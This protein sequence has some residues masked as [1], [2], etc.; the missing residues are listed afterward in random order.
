MRKIFVNS[1]IF[2]SVFL[3]VFMVIASLNDKLFEFETIFGCVYS[4]SIPGA[5]VYTFKIK[6]IHD[7]SHTDYGVFVYGIIAIIIS[8][9]IYIVFLWNVIKN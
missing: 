2:S 9:L 4:F 8:P 3:I 7:L 5:L 6:R 1:L